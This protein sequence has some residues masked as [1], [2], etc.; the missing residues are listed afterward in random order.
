MKYLSYVIILTAFVYTLTGCFGYGKRF[1]RERMLQDP[2][3]YEKKRLENR[4]WLEKD[5]ETKGY[6]LPKYR[7]NEM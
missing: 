2:I 5:A 4:E 6:N 1:A 7:S 3:E